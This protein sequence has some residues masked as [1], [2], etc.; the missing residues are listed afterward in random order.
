MNFEKKIVKSEKIAYI[1]HIGKVEEVPMITGKLME[2]AY[3]N[4]ITIAG[5]PCALY[6]TDPSMVDPDQMV[7]DMVISI[8]GDVKSNGEVKIKEVPEHTVVSAIHKGD[9]NR[10][11]ETYMGT[12]NYIPENKYVFNGYHK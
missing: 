12:W 2:W 8:S 5:P 11:S 3:K 7:Y 1:K 9:Y 10:L 4:N 6:Y